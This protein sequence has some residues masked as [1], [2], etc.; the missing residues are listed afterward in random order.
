MQR[1]FK[2]LFIQLA[3]F[4]TME[5]V[6]KNVEDALNLFKAD[7]TNVELQD[8]YVSNAAILAMKLGEEQGMTD[9]RLE[10]ELR[11]LAAMSNEKLAAKKG[12]TIP[13][14]IKQEILKA[15]KD[16]QMTQFDPENIT[17]EVIDDIVAWDDEAKEKDD[18]QCPGCQLRRALEKEG[19]IGAEAIDGVIIG[20]QAPDVN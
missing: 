3:S 20:K 6:I 18:C 17:Q 15:Q 5:E 1:L 4:M 14:L 8:K 13:E 19:V 9:E 2:Q 11:R 12:I 7:P 16:G 10:S